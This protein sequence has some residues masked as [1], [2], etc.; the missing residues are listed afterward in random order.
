MTA[1]TPAPIFCPFEP[2]T[3]PHVDSARVHV[4]AW[5]RDRGL[6][7]EGSS[8]HR[9]ARADFAGFA[10]MTYPYAVESA[11]HLMAD[12]F[13]WLFLVD[14]E[15]DDGGAGRRPDHV[16]QVLTEIEAVLATP[17]AHLGRDPRLAVA[18]LADLWRRSALRRSAAWRSRFIRHVVDCFTAA[19]WE[20]ENR[21]HG[22]I[23]D[24]RTYIAKRRH[25]GAIYICMDLIE[26]AAN[27]EIPPQI[28]ADPLFQ[29]ALDAACNVICWTNDVFSLRKERSL[30][31][32]HN[33]VHIVEH[34]RGLS[35]DAAID[36]VVQ[37]ISTETRRYLANE[38]RLLESARH[39]DVARYATGMR[40]WIR[41]NLDW[42]QTTYR[43]LDRP[44]P[45]HPEPTLL[46]P[47]VLPR[48]PT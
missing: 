22:T 19:C 32:Y 41:G 36:H 35:T 4:T 25:T 14:D 17:G 18:T 10:A 40:S 44:A 29:R 38:R 6:V 26:V 47:A 12:W 31:E 27:I 33:L 37:T 15:L 16:R 5:V 11:I 42:S 34:G 45:T 9:F 39:P 3:N 13:A 23:P 21:I 8:H 2:A 28:V 1:D 43:Y 24:E 30:G 48:R 20:A 7:R 46:G